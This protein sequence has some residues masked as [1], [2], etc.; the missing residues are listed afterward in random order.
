MAKKKPPTRHGRP[1]K[2]G[3]REAW[4]VHV[5]VELAAAVDKWRKAAQLSRAATIEKAL[6]EML[7]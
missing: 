1:P 5:P 6:R 2:Y 7:G 3:Q 4:L